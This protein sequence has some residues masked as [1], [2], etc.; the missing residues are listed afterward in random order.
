MNPAKEALVV[1]INGPD[2]AKWTPWGSD[3]AELSRQV[4][5]ADLKL[6]PAYRHMSDYRLRLLLESRED[7]GRRENW[8]RVVGAIV[9]GRTPQAK[10]IGDAFDL[11]CAKL[12]GSSGGWFRRYGFHL[13][14]VLPMDA[15][16]E[17]TRFWYTLKIRANDLLGDFVQ[18][19]LVDQEAQVRFVLPEFNRDLI[20]S[21]V[22]ELRGSG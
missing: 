7:L 3:F 13:V 20:L 19:R 5:E 10:D 11:L 1:V 15:T 9:D 17:H 21:M 14:V 12:Q 16:E 2:P 18:V 6:P 8:S 22:K 4:D